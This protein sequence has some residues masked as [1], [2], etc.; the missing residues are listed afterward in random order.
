MVPDPPLGNETLVIAG[1]SNGAHPLPLPAISPG[2][3][4][5]QQLGAS[6]MVTHCSADVQPPASCTVTQYCP[7]QSPEID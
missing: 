5:L 1:G 6:L 4:T 3:V 7:A 2:D